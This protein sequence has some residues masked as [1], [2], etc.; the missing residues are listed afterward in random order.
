MEVQCVGLAEA[1]GLT[2]AV[3]RI[4]V[5]APWSWLPPGWVPGPLARLGAAGDRLTPPWPDILISCGRRSVAPAIAVRKAAAGQTFTIHIQDPLTDLARFDVIVAPRHDGLRGANVIET[6]GGLN[7]NSP[8]R[9]AEAAER[10]APLLDDVPRP[11]LAVMI[12]GNNKAYRFTEERM[13]RLGAELAA[14][15]RAHEAGLLI[16]PSRRTAPEIMAAL[17]RA[18]ADAP[19]RIWD[20]A[21]DNP[22]LAYL[23]LADA[24]AV[25]ADS[26]NMVCEAASTGKPVFVIGLDG[27]SPKFNR[28]HQNLR[29]MGITRPFEGRLESWAYTPLRDTEIAAAEIRRRLVARGAPSGR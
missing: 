28:F 15:A 16:T 26:V 9:L 1:L 12:G 29:E 23:A 2:P 18:L 7:R 8:A 20:G 13:T 27:G 11:R 10:F 24:F 5:P 17:T 14:L 25:T 6:V 4:H 19:A 21:G 22:Y 3:K